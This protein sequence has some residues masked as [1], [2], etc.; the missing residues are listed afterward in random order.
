VS[1]V[2]RRT[3]QRRKKGISARMEVLYVTKELVNSF[4]KKSTKE[5]S[6]ISFGSVKQNGLVYASAGKGVQACA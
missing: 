3:A 6:F 4:T 2:S 1:A 5:S